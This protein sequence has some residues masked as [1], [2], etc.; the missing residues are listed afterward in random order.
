[1]QDCNSLHFCPFLSS[2]SCASQKEETRKPKLPESLFNFA[3]DYS[4]FLLSNKIVYKPQ[5]F[6][7][8][9]VN[10]RQVKGILRQTADYAFL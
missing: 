9:Q 4:A 7:D 1:M 10:L 5:K 2:L 3:I 6:C 8:G